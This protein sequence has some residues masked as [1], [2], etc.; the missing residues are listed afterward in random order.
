MA[1]ESVLIGRPSDAE[2]S[3]KLLGTAWRPWLKWGWV[4]IFVGIAGTISLLTG[5]VLTV[6]YGI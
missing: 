2:L 4:P 3:E 5:I 6:T 1:T